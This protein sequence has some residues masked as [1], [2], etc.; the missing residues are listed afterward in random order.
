MKL[1]SNR[2]FAV[3]CAKNFM[4]VFILILSLITI[5]GCPGSKK[6]LQTPVSQDPV[7]PQET[8]DP[9]PA[10]PEYTPP[11]EETRSAN[12][13]ETASA[14]PFNLQTIYFEFDRHDL[15]SEAL[16]LLA[17]NAR[18]LKAH[19]DAR[20]VVAGHCDERGTVEYNLALGDK[21]ANAAKDY[22]VSLGVSSSQVSVISYGKERPFDSS[23]SESGW[24]KNRR[25]EFERR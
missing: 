20:I 5:T 7:E 17:D 12:T 15:T 2:H 6:T 11:A 13:T 25:A 10:V 23:Q 22:L 1:P 3:Q 16:Q 21:R 14:A 4:R 9:E 8:R 19:P 24:A 18:V